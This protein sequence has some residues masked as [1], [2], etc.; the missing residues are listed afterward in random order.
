MISRRDEKIPWTNEWK[1][2]ERQSEVANSELD[3][4]YRSNVT[5]EIVSLSERRNKVSFVAR[6]GPRC[7][8]LPETWQ[9]PPLPVN[10]GPRVKTSRTSTHTYTHCDPSIAF[11]LFPFS[12]SLSLLSFFLFEN[13]GSRRSPTNWNEQPRRTR[14]FPPLNFPWPAYLAKISSNRLDHSKTTPLYPHAS[15]S[16]EHVHTLFLKDRV[17]FS[18]L[19]Q[20]YFCIFLCICNRCYRGSFLS[21]SF[22]FPSPFH[23]HTVVFVF[24]RWNLQVSL[25]S[26]SLATFY[27]RTRY[28]FPEYSWVWWM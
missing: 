18:N 14:S 21:L 15:I 8:S 23:L 1:S 17:F 22:S 11:L 10:T 27:L 19:F 16:I 26:S 6:Q 7:H 12:F 28:C 9:T 4:T 25:V 5:E 2:R 13:R 3:E 20:L 24:N